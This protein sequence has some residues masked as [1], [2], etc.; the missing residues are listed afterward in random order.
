MRS[1]LGLKGIRT[2]HSSLIIPKSI[3]TFTEPPLQSTRREASWLAKRSIAHVLL[4]ALTV[5][6]SADVASGKK[7]DAGRRSEFCALPLGSA[8]RKTARLSN[9]IPKG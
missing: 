1:V 3:V 9:S 5:Q 8:T 6:P 2:K 4:L 7:R